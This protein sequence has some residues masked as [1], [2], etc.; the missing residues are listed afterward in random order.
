MASRKTVLKVAATKWNAFRKEL[1]QKCK[2]AGVP[3][4]RTRSGAVR[5]GLLPPK[6]PVSKVHLPIDHNRNPTGLRK[7]TDNRVCRIC[8]LPPS[9]TTWRR[10]G[11]GQIRKP[12]AAKRRKQNRKTRIA[13]TAAFEATLGAN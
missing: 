2:L 9:E 7:K 1:R 6:R 13:A 5:A 12:C 8:L 4:E 3:V 10:D 11:S